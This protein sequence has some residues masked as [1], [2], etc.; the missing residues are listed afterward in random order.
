[1][2]QERVGQLDQVR[3]DTVARVALHDG[4]VRGLG[5]DSTDLGD[6]TRAS[7][8]AGLLADGDHSLVVAGLVLGQVPLEGV[9]LT[10]GHAGGG[11]LEGDAV[12]AAG[13]ET[14]LSVVAGRLHDTVATEL[15][16]HGR[17][18]VGADRDVTDVLVALGR[19]SACRDEQDRDLA[20]QAGQ[21][22]VLRRDLPDAAVETLVLRSHGG[23]GA[24]RGPGLALQSGDGRLRFGELTVGLGLLVE[25]GLDGRA[26][27]GV[28]LLLLLLGRGEPP[29]LVR[30][31]LPLGQD[32]VDGQAR[33]GG[34]RGGDLGGDVLDGLE[35]RGLRRRL[36]G[37]EVVPP[38]RSYTL[39][40]S[41][42]TLSI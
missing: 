33:S 39:A 18:G 17:D 4:V 40:H 3:V 12:G 26:G 34:R 28:G 35:L 22:G 41:A 20:D 27:R 15:V 5:G 1:M 37:H 31:T 10:V 42:S 14:Q 21:T 32:V 13:V 8:A 25:H 9:G 2:L 6:Q 36:V 23:E 29:L 24:D 16:R 30:G 38:D 11:Q 19:Q 7:R